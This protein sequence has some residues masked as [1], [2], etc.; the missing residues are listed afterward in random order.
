[1]RCGASRLYS[2]AVD[3]FPT[4]TLQLLLQDQWQQGWGRTLAVTAPQAMPIG[5]HRAKYT[6]TDSVGNTASCV[7]NVT[8]VDDEDPVITCP[9]TELRYGTDYDAD[10]RT[11]TLPH[12]TAT[13][14]D[15]LGNTS[16]LAPPARSYP[17]GQ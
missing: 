5:R 6:V 8:V 1:M 11:I 17:I 9:A 14:N 16:W 4:V 10:T 7:A 13:D 3:P 2:D 15:G 12:A